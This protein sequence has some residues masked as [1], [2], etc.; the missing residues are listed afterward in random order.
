MKENTASGGFVKKLAG[1]WRTRLGKVL[2]IA[3][4]LVVLVCALLPLA[5]HLHYRTIGQELEER[6]HD[7]TFSSS[8]WLMRSGYSA[9]ELPSYTDDE[10]EAYFSDAEVSAEPSDYDHL[11]EEYVIL[12]LYISTDDG[13]QPNE[14][15]YY[16]ENVQCAYACGR[17]GFRV[18]YKGYSY[19]VS[20]AQLNQLMERICPLSHD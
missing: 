20:S 14:D 16:H 9:Y 12:N 5:E 6:L 18:S 13:I 3:A 8:G 2:C 11:G 10:W 4:V 17:E 19:A 1:I 7:G 15:G